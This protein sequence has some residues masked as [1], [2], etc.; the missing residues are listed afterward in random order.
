MTMAVVETAVR[1][2]ADRTS[3]AKVWSSALELTAPITRHP[4]RI[5][6]TV[7]EE[8]AQKIGTAP[9]LMSDGECLTYR[10]LGERSI[11]YALWAIDQ[12]LAKGD[13]V[14]LLMPNCPEYMA[15]WLG[16]TRVG[17]VVALLNTNLTGSSLAHCINAAAPRYLIVA[18]E[19]ADRLTGVRQDLAGAPTIWVH[20]AGHDQFPRIDRDV[21]RYASYVPS[22]PMLQGADRRRVTIDDRALYIYTS[23]TTGPPKAAVVTHGRVM[24]WS[25]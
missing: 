6:P 18:G 22:M 20:G 1:P 9:A 16:I 5:L 7:V 14:C 13:A 19:L 23:G 17:G 8:L 12:G 21:E 24:Q 25:Q 2:A 11:R 10:A 15:I 4:D 3:S